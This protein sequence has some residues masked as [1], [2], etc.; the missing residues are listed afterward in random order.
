M[1][2]IIMLMSTK[3]IQSRLSE[4]T[5]ILSKFENTLTRFKCHNFN[6]FNELCSSMALVQSNHIDINEMTLSSTDND[7]YK[8][9]KCPST[10][11][12]ILF[13]IKIIHERCYLYFLKLIIAWSS[14]KN[15]RKVSKR[16]VIK[17]FYS[18]DLDYLKTTHAKP[19]TANSQ[20]ARCK[21]RQPL[22]CPNTHS[23]SAIP[24]GCA[25]EQKSGGCAVVYARSHLVKTLSLIPFQRCQ[26]WWSIDEF[27]LE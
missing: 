23:S 15:Q 16:L 4:S 10:F 9:L 17:E 8:R 26:L 7:F 1:P 13:S 21:G 14:W 18:D 19:E 20:S 25:T 12:T 6:I 2:S 11:L 24:M 5:I 22:F 27:E 3:T